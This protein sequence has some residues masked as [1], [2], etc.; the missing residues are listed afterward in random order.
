MIK[1]MV[2]EDEPPILRSICSIIEAVNHEFKVIAMAD[3]GSDAIRM[4]ETDIP[5][6]LFTDIQMSVVDGL[7]LIQHIRDKDLDIKVVILSG[8]SEFNYARSAMALGVEDYLLK[9]LDRSELSVLLS[10]LANDINGKRNKRQRE[11]FNSVIENRIVSTEGDS[12]ISSKGY[13]LLMLFCAGSFPTYSLDYYSPRRVFWEN[14]DLEK[15]MLKFLHSDESCFAFKGTTGAERVAVLT[16]K[17]SSDDRAKYIAA[18]ALEELNKLYGCINIGISPYIEKIETAGGI[19]N[20][21]RTQLNKKMV[22]AKSQIFKTASSAQSLDALKPDM[23]VMDTVNQKRILKCAESGSISSLKNELLNL[24]QQWE[25]SSFLQIWVEKLV[26]DVVFLCLG[27]LGLSNSFNSTD[28]ELQ[29]NEAVSNSNNYKELFI[30]VWYIFEEMFQIKLKAGYSNES[31]ELLMEKVD[32]YIAGNLTEQI[33]NQLLSE[34][35]GL[36]PSY[37]SKLF[38]KHKGMS[39]ADYLFHLRIEK[40]KEVIEGQPDILTKDIAAITGFC[41]PFHFSKVF[42]RKTGMSPSEYK[43]LVGKKRE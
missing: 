10:K 9:P 17:D 7:A 15:L 34:K 16:L 31:I 19:L 25:A 12:C 39:P 41:D 33:N 28:L 37:L 18:S 30:N 20:D 1:V 29:I 8:Y 23:P 6:V 3:S 11:F 21:L 2:V 40:A 27:G 5:D 14:T 36:V 38:R 4:L 26:K 22:F 35:F 42:K 43:S 24:F 32:M 13:L